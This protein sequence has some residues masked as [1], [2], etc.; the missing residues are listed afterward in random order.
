[1]LHN[2]EKEAISRFVTV[3]RC[4]ARVTQPLWAA[5]NRLEQAQYHS[6][7][8]TGRPHVGKCFP[9]NP[10]STP[11]S[12]TRIIRSIFCF[13][14]MNHGDAGTIVRPQKRRFA[15]SAS[16]KSLTYSIA[17]ISPRTTHTAA[18]TFSPPCTSSRNSATTLCATK[19]RRLKGYRQNPRRRN[20]TQGSSRNNLVIK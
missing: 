5:S 6:R 9:Q 13:L 2:N 10:R 12:P 18:R 4:G 11:T 15:T 16:R 14:P 7:A 17:N 20:S 19:Q 3:V 8:Q 1:M